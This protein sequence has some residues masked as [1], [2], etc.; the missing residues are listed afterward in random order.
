MNLPAASDIVTSEFVA[1]REELDQYIQ[2]K[3][4]H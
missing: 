1:G 2:V 3:E 4:F